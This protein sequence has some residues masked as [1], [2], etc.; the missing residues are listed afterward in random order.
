MHEEGS[1]DH[2]GH[3]HA[4]TWAKYAGIPIPQACLQKTFGIGEHI[5]GESVAFDQTPLITEQLSSDMVPFAWNPCV[6]E[7]DLGRLT[8]IQLSFIGDGE[9][10][11]PRVGPELDNATCTMDEIENRGAA[12]LAVLMEDADEEVN[13]VTGIGIFFSDEYFFY[14]GNYTLNRL[15][16][17]IESNQHIVG[18]WGSA[19]ETAIT[20][21]GLILQDID[22]THEEAQKV[23]DEQ[24]RLKEEEEQSLLDKGLDELLEDAESSTVIIIV[25]IVVTVVVIAILILL[26]CCVFRRKNNQSISKV[27]MLKS[28]GKQQPPTNNNSQSLPNIETDDDPNLVFADNYTKRSEG[29]DTA[30]ALNI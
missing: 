10:D 9:Y 19:T 16:I 4:S 15:D 23:L 1:G 26:V 5:E 20:Q 25:V 29:K 22:C 11:M 3:D 27:Q 2:E 7:G 13:K 14:H 18:F 8:S 17:K 28:G 12:D 21:L 30:R 24:A 6:L